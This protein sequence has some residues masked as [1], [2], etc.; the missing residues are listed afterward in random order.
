MT[1]TQSPVLG[2]LDGATTLGVRR[3]LVIDP[4]WRVIDAD[5]YRSLWKVLCVE[6]ASYGF[7]GF[8]M[9]WTTRLRVPDTENDDNGPP[10]TCG[11]PG[12]FKVRRLV[13]PVATIQ[14]STYSC[15]I[16]VKWIHLHAL[17]AGG[18]ADALQDPF[19]P[20]SAHWPRY[21][22]GQ[23][24]NSEAL[25][26]EVYT[27]T[28]HLI[29]D[30]RIFK[31]GVG[32][33]G[34]ETKLHRDYPAVQLRSA[35]DLVELADACLPDTVLDHSRPRTNEDVTVV[36]T[37]SLRSLKS[38]CCALTGRQ[39]GK[40]MA[41]V[42]SDW[43]GCHGALTPLQIEYAAEDAEASYDVCVAILK[44]GGFIVDNPASAAHSHNTPTHLPWKSVKELDCREV[45]ACCA[46][47]SV[48][49]HDCTSAAVQD[50]ENSAGG[51]P[52]DAIQ[53]DESAPVSKGCYSTAADVEDEISPQWCKGRE[54]PYYDNISIFDPDMQ[55]AFT[56]DKTKADWYV[57]KK[58]LARVVQWRTPAGVI[59]S[60]EER[61]AFADAVDDL[62][63]AAIQLSF[64]PNFS[65]YNDA[66]VPRN[67]EYFRQPKENICV[68]CGS[69]GS[70]VRFAVVPLM[71]RR[72][73]PSVYMSHNS[74]DLLLLCSH[75]F[76]KSRRLYDRLRQ[77]VADD[78]GIPLIRLRA[79]Q[80]EEYADVVRQ[81]SQ[82]ID[83]SAAAY[84]EA[85]GR[86]LSTVEREDVPERDCDL[87]PRLRL[88]GMQD[89]L[90]LTEHRE[91]LD[92]VFSFA[93]A[94]HH[95]YEFLRRQEEAGDS[96]GGDIDEEDMMTSSGDVSSPSG[97]PTS[98][99]RSHKRHG[100]M[101]G[102][103]RAVTLTILPE[104]RRTMMI[105]YLRTHASPYPF[106]AGQR[107]E[108]SSQDGRQLQ[109]AVFY[110]DSDGAGSAQGVRFIL[111]G[112]AEAPPTTGYVCRDSAGVQYDNSSRSVLTRYWVGEHPE[113]LTLLPALTRAE[114]RL[115]QS[116]DNGKV[117]ESHGGIVLRNSPS[118]D[119]AADCE[120]LEVPY[121]DSHA[122]LVVRLL[123]EKYSYVSSRAKTG[124]HAVGQ[125]IFRWRSSFVEGMHPQHLPRG[126]T[127]EDG[128]L[129]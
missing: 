113:L 35:V 21:R 16:V 85:K 55:L 84:E 19:A 68:V 65:R 114:E 64:A 99:K 102:T 89:F 109:E 14:L 23:R 87:H 120:A 83:V 45:L 58:G 50:A 48:S 36:R 54:R 112:V 3:R 52:R 108:D 100:Q 115:R 92:K 28:L 116:V 24:Q 75:C 7:V 80:R 121:V 57:K 69:G 61:A 118:A 32:I 105:D 96:G 49:V 76:A 74:Y 31:T 129:R 82:T 9:E 106:F 4:I 111:T 77:N 88:R 119:S 18:F 26:H 91:I 103:A 37:D 117:R 43:G 126:W 128:I 34:D 124:E 125:F 47:E 67:M 78:F 27:N 110:A 25:L 97:I 8:D 101:A 42:M 6:A 107:A 13:G 51:V 41:V 38:M 11:A 2:G 53:T 20:A 5:E 95:H 104:K 122:F 127:P 123:L 46:T 63:V 73:F 59:L 29:H 17:T 93:K 62:E 81:M 1:A 70:L 98:R 40:D 12:K 86:V 39:L 94:L 56:V 30:Q 33:H 71:Y 66:H 79:K 60:E 22:E 44:G 72:F 10:K 15:T 90:S